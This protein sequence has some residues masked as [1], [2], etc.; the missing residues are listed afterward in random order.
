MSEKKTRKA[1]PRKGQTVR[2]TFLDHVEDGD[3]LMECTVYGRLAKTTKQEYQVDSW[4]CKDPECH[5][6][7]KKRFT[8]LRKAVLEIVVLVPKG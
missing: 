4:C 7:N 8:L 5:E 1:A 3:E 2:V 6:N